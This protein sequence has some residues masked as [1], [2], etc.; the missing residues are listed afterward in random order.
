M[1]K[2]R[3]ERN[4]EQIVKDL[5]PTEKNFII[6]F[7]LELDNGRF[8]PTQ[9]LKLLSTVGKNA[10]CKK[11]TFYKCIK[12]LNEKDIISKNTKSS[13]LI[14]TNLGWKVRKH[15]LE[16]RDY[17]L[18]KNT[19]D[20]RDLLIHRVSKNGMFNKSKSRL[21]KWT[22]VFGQ[23]LKRISNLLFS[24]A[25]D[26]ESDLVKGLGLVL[27]NTLY[28]PNL[29]S[30][31]EFYN[32]TKPES[33]YFKSCIYT[34]LK[35]LKWNYYSFDSG[36]W[37]I[38]KNSFYIIERFNDIIR[39]M[40][41]KEKHDVIKSESFWESYSFEEKIKLLVL[42]NED[43]KNFVLDII[44]KSIQKLAQDILNQDGHYYNDTDT[45]DSTWVVD[46]INLILKSHITS[47]SDF[48]YDH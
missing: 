19:L 23:S 26:I 43:S 8:I 45:S 44:D 40:L 37:F 47:L 5:S 36:I 29:V 17:T 15:I 22:E 16:E 25:E 14:I 33:E 35:F 38:T 32:I 39:F 34:I 41:R 4:L 30:L 9:E 46:R 12:N 28:Q 21:K 2:K 42:L 10:I 27:W 6:K 11:A 18:S 24:A 48:D 13:L 7:D 3:R 1:N 31:E 20:Q